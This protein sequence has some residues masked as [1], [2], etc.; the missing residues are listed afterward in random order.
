LSKEPATDEP[1]AVRPLIAI[2]CRYL[3]DRPSGIGPYQRALVDHLP[4]LA[5]D[6]DFLLI[7]H[8]EAKNRLSEAPNAKDLL[9]P[10]E[11]NGPVTMWLM[12]FADFRSAN[13]FH[14]TFNIQPA[15]MPLPVV[16][17]IHDVMEVKYPDFA[18]YPGIWGRVQKAFFRNGVERALRLSVRIATVSQATR[19]EIATVDPG[20]AERARVTPNGIGAEWHPARSAEDR[21]LAESARNRYLPGARRYVL[22]VGQFAPYKNHEGVVK[23]FARTFQGDSTTHLALVQRLGPGSRRLN[24]LARELGILERVHFL[25]NLPF[26]DLLALYW[27]A[28]ALCHPSFYEGFGMPPLEAL[29]SGCPVVTSNCSSMPEV[30]GDAALLVDPHDESAI[31]SALGRIANEPHTAQALREAGIERSQAFRWE[32]T[33]E[34][35]LAIYREVLGQL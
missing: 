5:P 8:H 6:L 3:R 2:D 16:T 30:V 27:G 11:P 1:E 26:P 32:V 14:A 4:R 22:T 9:Y 12:R 18:F 21:A 19:D 15:G 25:R 35:T 28:L 23:A 13:L 10:W 20:A 24:P 7:R 29:A 17:T 34:R 33:A 31:A